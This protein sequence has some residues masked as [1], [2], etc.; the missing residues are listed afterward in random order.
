[1]GA[2]EL[3]PPHEGGGAPRRVQAAAD[4]W[5]YFAAAGEGY[6]RDGFYAKAI[7]VYVRAAAFLPA[8]VDLWLTLADLNL[9]RQR[10]ADAFKACLDGRR[11]FP[12]LAQHHQAGQLLRRALEIEPFHVETTLDLARV[13]R[14]TGQREEATRLLRG[15]AVRNRGRPLRRIRGAQVRLSPTPAALWRWLRAAVAGR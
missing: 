14:R 9:R 13:L 7:A 11:H 4:A 12:G 6:A 3:R 2:A 10:K 5:P 1:M 8:K 15:I